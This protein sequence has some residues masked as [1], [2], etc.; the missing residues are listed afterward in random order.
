MVP[1]LLWSIA[2]AFW[3]AAFLI[4]YRFAVDAAPRLTAMAAMFLAAGVF[5]AAIAAVQAFRAQQARHATNTNT[6]GVRRMRPSEAPRHRVELVAAIAL[7]VCTIVANFGIAIALPRVGTGM[8]SVILKSQVVLTPILAM[9]ALGERMPGYFWAG[10]LVALTGVALPVV[11]EPDLALGVVGYG[12]A[13]VAA[14]GFAAMQIVTR[15]VIDRIRPAWVNA[16]RLF[17]C[18]GLLQLLSDGRQ[19]WSIDRTAWGLA[20]LA[21]VFGPGFS[22]L[23]L[24]FA[25]RYVS[26]SVTALVALFGPLFAFGLGAVFFDEAPTAVDLL[27]AA[28]ILAGVLWALF[29]ALLSGFRPSGEYETAS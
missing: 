17:M 7:T 8:T 9:F 23:S 24:M 4:P 2:A 26:P 18:F 20:I 11:Q 15:R 10:A 14:V 16:L 29:P 28:I 19:V 12:A 5:N 22:R 13:T 1:G 21:A 27:G 25:V 6:A 3:A